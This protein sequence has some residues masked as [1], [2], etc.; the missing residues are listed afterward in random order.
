[1]NT[2]T[3]CGDIIEFY[4]GDLI[5]EYWEATGDWQE[6][7]PFRGGEQTWGL[8]PPALRQCSSTDTHSLSY[9]QV[10]PAQ[11]ISDRGFWSFIL[12]LPL[13]TFCLNKNIETHPLGSVMTVHP[14]FSHL[15]SSPLCTHST[16][17]LLSLPVIRWFICSLG[18]GHLIS[19][20]NCC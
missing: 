20:L 7:A 13:V 4:S 15:L 16:P 2:T 9:S 1:M 3:T 12:Q 14:S 5:Y 8:L 10:T 6:E 19:L 18:E 11:T 17:I